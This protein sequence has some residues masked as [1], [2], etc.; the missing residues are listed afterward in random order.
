ML[1]KIYRD[2]NVSNRNPGIGKA[3]FGACQDLAMY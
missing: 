1:G 3:T 2:P